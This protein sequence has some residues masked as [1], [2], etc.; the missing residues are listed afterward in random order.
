MICM[1]SDQ[2]LSGPGLREESG[3]VLL[4]QCPAI[5][6]DCGVCVSRSPPPGASDDLAPRVEAFTRHASVSRQE[7]VRLSPPARVCIM[8]HG[9]R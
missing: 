7:M 3:L 6:F 5:V 8:L 4:S 1:V 2:P 9:E